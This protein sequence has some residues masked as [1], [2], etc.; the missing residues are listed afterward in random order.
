[1]KLVCEKRASSMCAV[2]F[3]PFPLQTLSHRFK[4]CEWCSPDQNDWPDGLKL[5]TKIVTKKTKR[6]W[7]SD[8]Q[9][10]RDEWIANPNQ[11]AA[12]FVSK[13]ICY[14]K[15]WQQNAVYDVDGNYVGRPN[16]IND[17]DYDFT[18]DYVPED[19]FDLPTDL[20]LT[21]PWHRDITAAKL[22]LYKGI[23]NLSIKLN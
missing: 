15:N 23:N 9:E 5:P 12:G 21:T 13:M 14:R 18:A 10:M 22:I 17:E 4:R 7:Q 20:V 19:F 6:K 8:R 2:C 3:T 11:T 1:V 16:N